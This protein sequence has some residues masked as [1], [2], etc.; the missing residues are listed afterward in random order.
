[1]TPEPAVGN[2]AN[3]KSEAPALLYKQQLLFDIGP[4]KGDAIGAGFGPAAATAA[5]PRVVDQLPEAARAVSERLLRAE[6]DY[7][8]AIAQISTDPG[9]IG[10]NTDKII[11]YINDARQQS[12]RLVV[13]PELAV[14][15]YCSMDLFW[16]ADYISA[17]IAALDKIRDASDGI[18]VIVGFVD[19]DPALFRSGNRAM[20]YNSAAIIQDG[21]ILHVQDKS[22]LP[23]YDIFF[24]DRYFAPPRSRRVIE[25]DGIRIGTEICEDLWVDGYNVDPTAELAE[26]GADVVVNLSASPF[27]VG[28]LPV[29]H[30]LLART[31]KS[32]SVP[33]IY[34]NLV[35]SFDGYEG[36]VVFDGR[37]MVLGPKGDLRAFAAGFKEELLFVDVF[38][39]HEFELPQVEQVEELYE[40]LV[41]GIRDYFR[42]VGAVNKANFKCSYIGLSGGIDS[43]V[44]AAIAVEALGAD[45]VVGLT[46]PSQ[47][48]SPETISDADILAKNLGVKIKTVPIQGQVAAC[49][50]TLRSDP[51][52]AALPEGVAE[53]NIQARLR[54]IDL[55][56]YAN[57]TQGLVLNTGN[58]TELALDNCTIYGD[59]VGGFS[60]LGDVDKDRVYD[61]ARYINRRAGRELIPESTISRVPSA[62]LK[63]NQVDA[64]VMG[65][66]PQVIAPLVRA[67]I[68]EKLTLNQTLNR[69]EKEFGADLILRTFQKIDRSEWKRRQAAPAIRVTPHSFGNGRRMPMAHGFYQQE[70]RNAA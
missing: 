51:E 60:V 64:A 59:M 52:M 35:G 37:S 47:Y 31:A 44:V 41:L 53:E 32:H 17:N 24:E 18:T 69:F 58:K 61:L 62:E 3:V 39:E 43:A 66:E 38:K 21:K 55:M 19:T 46:M 30:E 10:K 50:D 49:L 54:M 27:H 33:M 25:A 56:Y 34:A 16:D 45:K 42:R 63:P 57:K 20:L 2:I 11:R 23:N 14:P 5:G 40:A 12:A 36:E 4:Y 6:S 13:F 68:E 7:R 70:G 48:N 8:V 1:M 26:Q 65:A 22:L 15:G 9:E 28:K 67:I 29:R